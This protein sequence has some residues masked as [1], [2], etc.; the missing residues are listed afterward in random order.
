MGV[1]RWC[2]DQ[3]TVHLHQSI[4]T[5]QSN[6]PKRAFSSWGDEE[7]GAHNGTAT[8]VKV[9]QLNGRKDNKVAEGGGPIW[10]NHAT[11]EQ[12]FDAVSIFNSPWCSAPPAALHL[13]SSIRCYPFARLPN[14][15]IFTPLTSS[16]D[17][18]II[19]HSPHRMY[20]QF[21]F[22]LQRSHNLFTPTN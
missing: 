1:E 2:R 17:F 4:S 15:H 18:R 16:G 6:T 13:V 21:E 9:G 7:T 5:S 10:W 20:S 12:R 8:K 22:V 3:L 19:H 14:L 11:L